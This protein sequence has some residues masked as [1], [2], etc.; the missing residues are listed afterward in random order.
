ME[1]IAVGLALTS[2]GLALKLMT[3]KSALTKASMLL[4]QEKEKAQ[5]A[6]KELAEVVE[7]SDARSLKT[8][9]L[10]SF[11]L[12]STNCYRTVEVK[13]PVKNN[14]CVEEAP[15]ALPGPVF[16]QCEEWEACLSKENAVSLVRYLNKAQTYM[17]DWYIQCGKK[18]D[19][20][21][22]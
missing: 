10:V 1:F 11:V 22:E 21:E 17:N 12:T 5:E 9:L 4:E 6:L 18:E 15:P 16:S 19:K 20:D 13:V 14:D 7:R 2:V 3:M 8:L